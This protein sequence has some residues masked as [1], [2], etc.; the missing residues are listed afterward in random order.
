MDPSKPTLGH[1]SEASP[2]QSRKML[3]TVGLTPDRRPQMKNLLEMTQSHNQIMESVK[4][5]PGSPDQDTKCIKTHQKPLH[6]ATDSEVVPVVLSPQKVQ[7]LGG[8]SGPQPKDMDSMDLS[9]G[10]QNVKSE[11]RIL[12]PRLQSMKSIAIA[13]DLVP[14]MVNYEQLNPAMESSDLG[15]E[16]HWKNVKSEESTPI[17]QLQSEKSVQPA[18]ESQLPDV[19][20]VQLTTTPQLQSVQSAGLAPEP[21]F[22]SKKSV[23]FTLSSQSQDVVSVHLALPQELKQDI[24]TVA[25]TPGPPSGDTKS[26]D[27]VPKPCLPN[28]SS[29]KVGPVPLLEDM[30]TPQLIE[31]MKV[32][33][34]IPSTCL[35]AVKSLE[36]SPNPSYHFTESEGLTQGHQVSEVGATEAKLL[37]PDPCHQVEESAG[38]TQSSLGIV[39]PPSSQ[40]SESMEMN[41]ILFQDI[42]ETRTLVV[43]EIRKPPKSQDTIKDTLY[44]LPESEVQNMKD[45]LVLESQPLGEKSVPLNLEPCSEITK[46]PKI[47]LKAE[48]EDIESVGLILPKVD[49]MQ[50]A[51]PEAYSE[52]GA[53]ELSPRPRMQYEKSESL[54]QNL[55]CVELTSESSS[56]MVGSKPHVKDLIS[57]SQLQEVKSRKMDPESQMQDEKSVNLTQQSAIGVVD[58]EKPKLQPGL[59]SLS[60]EESAEGTQSQTV[61]C[62]DLNL[63]PQQPSIKSGL[64]PGPQLQSVRLLKLCLGPVH[65]EEKPMHLISGSPH[66]GVK[67]DEM[68][69]CSPVQDFRSTDIIPKL[70][71]PQSQQVKSVEVNLGPCLQDVRFSDLISEPEHQ[72]FKYIQFI[73]GIPFQNRKAQGFI[74][75]PFLQLNEESQVEDMR[76]DLPTEMSEFQGI[77]SMMPASELQYQGVMSEDVSPGLWQQDVKFSEL[78]SGLI[79]GSKH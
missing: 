21:P 25:L 14:E 48:N 6:Q 70:P 23:D 7:Y 73:P 19:E 43:K 41:S 77:K 76:L 49:D 71:E 58:P 17:P 15:P 10:L 1:H 30:K 4:T 18:S 52:T 56:L 42:Q 26:V 78:T 53:L 47:T 66:Y 35:Y 69:S 8:D 67:S 33:E 45:V 50:E 44:L 75:E 32:A 36:L 60:L 51:I 9:P 61:K 27:L 12:D 37:P 79:L 22:Q 59:Q 5:T 34:C 13:T 55:K 64:T 29:D 40:T 11:K 54:E 20:S 63:G 16:C 28:T 2:R 38:L 57:G 68:R 39:P 62:V 3:E 74:P 72:G 46:L 24:K 31:S 65:Q